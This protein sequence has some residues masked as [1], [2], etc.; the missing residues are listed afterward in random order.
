M[1]SVIQQ[2]LLDLG[3]EIATS[4]ADDLGFIHSIM[5]QCALPT[6]KPPE[7]VM[8]WE[9]SQGRAR[10][11]LEA[12]KVLDP[13]TGT[14]KQLTLPYGPKARL[15]LMHLNSEA[16]RRQSP[17][18]PV[19]DTMTA[20]F[21]RLMGRTQDGRQA[22]MLKLQLSSLAAATFRM[23]I[24]QDED[25]AFQVDTKVVGAFDLW[26]QNE[27][28]QRV[29]WPSTLRLSL[30]YYESLTR[31]AVPLDERAVAALAHSALALDIYCWLAQRLHRVPA[32]KP[33]FVSWAALYDQFG[34][35]YKE[36]RFFRRD[37]LNL[38]SQVKVVYPQARMS[39]EK[40]GLSLEHSPPP[41]AKRVIA[42]SS[43][44]TGN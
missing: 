24:V 4:P 41:V 15:L 16:V 14:Y 36:V 42:L 23:G 17:V 30:D 10:L 44:S 11:L 32:G 26:F 29:L 28:G 33:Q 13:R 35:G 22:K 18:I 1:A 19:E 31:F 6:V 20:F 25:R 40:R 3:T 38:L 21:R 2:R 43:L 12:G 37:F 9:R 27:P 8:V 39:E 5:A 7:G 34:Q